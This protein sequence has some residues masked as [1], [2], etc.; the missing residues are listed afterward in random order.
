M[1]KRKQMMKIS[2]AFILILLSAS[3]FSQSKREHVERAFGPI[4]ETTLSNFELIWARLGMEADNKE[5]NKVVPADIRPKKL[6]DKARIADIAYGTIEQSMT[7]E[8]IINVYRMYQTE[9]GK[10]TLKAVSESLKT[11][12][13]VNILMEQMMTQADSVAIEKEVE[14][15]FTREQV[16]QIGA[17]TQGL[18]EKL[19]Q[20]GIEHVSNEIN[21]YYAGRKFG[22]KDVT[23]CV[24]ATE[25]KRDLYAIPVCKI[26][27]DAGAHKA[28]LA[29]AS[30]HWQG[31]YQRG[32][33]DIA[34]AKTIYRSI[35]NQDESGEA[36]YML[37]MLIK[38][39]PE[40]GETLAQS[41][42]SIKQAQNKGYA[43]AASVLN[44]FPSSF[45]DLACP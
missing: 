34:Q 27:H 30:L 32:Q 3:A 28:S 39:A 37:G 18:G 8:E 33:R 23:L 38:N 45:Q 36:A 43:Q 29:L 40:Q 26:G 14:A 13:P 35:L 31:R 42:C 20:A 7:E 19:Q 15:M 2:L 10:I 16:N 22:K 4:V 5:F 44:E 11:G 17:S 24:T 9:I 41:F 6:L 25:L 21:A 1:Q 12:Q